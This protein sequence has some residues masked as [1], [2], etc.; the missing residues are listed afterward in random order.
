MNKIEKY[1]KTLNIIE[2]L[3]SKNGVT[4]STENLNDLLDILHREFKSFS[5][6]GFYMLSNSKKELLLGEYIGSPAA[7]VIPINSGVCGKCAREEASVVVP[8]VS[9]FDGHIAC[10][11]TT[12]SEIC[13]PIHL[14]GEFV[15][16]L[17]IDSNILNNFDSS[18]KKY[19]ECI[20]NQIGR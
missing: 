5:W 14:K 3:L 12:K 8:D 1:E 11:L 18:D 9:K 6:L 20:V 13:I 7:K 2:N 15:G 4:N 19:L 10:S 16:L 17:D